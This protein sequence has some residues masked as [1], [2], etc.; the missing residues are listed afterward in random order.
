MPPAKKRKTAAKAKGSKKDHVVTAKASSPP[1]EETQ[2]ESVEDTPP[3]P[4]PSNESVSEDHNTMTEAPAPPATNT[5]QGPAAPPP[6]E[7]LLTEPSSSSATAI[8][9][10]APPTPAAPATTLHDRLARQRALRNRFQAGAAAN[11][12]AAAAE[13]HRLK[14]DPA[15]LAPL[16][17]RAAV[18]AQKL[19]K[20][21]IEAAGG[22]FERMRAMDWTVDEAARWDERLAA[23]AAARDNNAFQDYAAEAGRVYE[24]QV[25]NMGAP[26]VEAYHRR[27]IK[28]IE[29][30]AARGTLEL[31]E[32]EDGEM[33]AVNRDGT[34]DVI[35]SFADSRPSKE[36]VDRLVG[37]MKKNDEVAAKKRRE[38]LAKNGQEDGDVTYINDANKRFNQK[39]NRAYNKFNNVAET[40]DSL[41]RG[42]AI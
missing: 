15:Q 9:I 18:A 35:S 12:T 29:E 14:H 30:G 4:E 16:Q 8:S 11:L 39:L 42:T 41:E 7:S 21:D 13:A 32:T 40:K 19:T 1:P 31:C 6:Q 24:R 33:V 38:R 34:Y 2:P 17:R 22:D 20:A 28:E 23:R 36:A 26:D 5:E 37:T 27:K 10:Q 25:R 3:V